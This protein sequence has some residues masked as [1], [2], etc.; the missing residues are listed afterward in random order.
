MLPLLVMLPMLIML[1]T[2]FKAKEGEQKK[3]ERRKD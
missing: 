3:K 1:R 2:C